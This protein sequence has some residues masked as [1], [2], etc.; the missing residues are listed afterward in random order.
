M[1]DATSTAR[2]A[3]NGRSSDGGST[4]ES[5]EQVRE[6]LRT[7]AERGGEEGRQAV[8]RWM[9]DVTVA[10]ADAGTQL[11]TDGHAVTALAAHTAAGR[12]AHVGRFVEGKSLAE[13]ADGYADF[14]RRRPGVAI[15][16]AFVAGF[17]AAAL[18]QARRPLMQA[19][20]E[21]LP[22]RREDEI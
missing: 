13:I 1:S 18:L 7:Q 19:A 22:D 6:M 5:A 4:P 3:S 2:S 15:G 10:L 8:A 20:E 9:R 12:L 21:R 16:L 17:G 11:Q 14:A